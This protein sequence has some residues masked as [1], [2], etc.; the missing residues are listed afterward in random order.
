MRVY[1]A[2]RVLLFVPTLAIASALVFLVMRVLPGDVALAILV[3]RETPG[4]V[5]NEDDITRLRAQLGLADPLPVQYLTW[6]RSLATGNAGLSLYTRRPVAE[7]IGE[8]LPVTLH[9]AVYTVLI[10]LF[11]SIPLGAL[12]AV[13]Q[14]RWPDYVVRAGTILGLATP[15]FWIGLIVLLLLVLLFRWVP[16]PVY[17]HVWE[18]ARENVSLLV[19]PAV[20]L[21]WRFS[22]YQARMVRA[23]LLE[24]LRQDYIRTAYSKGLAEP[25]VVLRHALRNAML[26]VLTLIGGELTA[27][28]SGTVILE[29]V[30]NV[31]GLGDALINAMRQRDYPVVENLLMFYMTF[32]LTINL[33]IDLVYA[34]I[35]PRIRYAE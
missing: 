26:P 27:L 6:V 5:A 12:A 4:V 16:S 33:V 2:K 13:R 29:N 9:L 1:I 21:A 17:Y 3:S 32:T 8:R 22:S 19:F 35:N 14:D 20:I 34:V 11:V 25:I 28:M 23:N 24:V 15:G 30:F 10:S 31:P 18:D 7:L